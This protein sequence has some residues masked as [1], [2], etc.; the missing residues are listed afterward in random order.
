ML[1]QAIQS[2]I[3]KKLTQ[4]GWLC[5]KIIKLSKSGYPDLLAIKNGIT[6]FIEVKQ[7]NGGLS[8]LQK[9]KIKELRDNGINVKVWED[10]GKDFSW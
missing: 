3:I 7:P 9:L 4:E 6:T 1:E 5:L 8:E 2:K 10:Y